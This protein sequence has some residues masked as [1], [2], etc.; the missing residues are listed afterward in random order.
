MANVLRR[1]RY[2]ASWTRNVCV[3]TLRCCR[4]WTMWALAIIIIFLLFI[5][6]KESNNQA[7]E[8]LNSSSVTYRHD[9]SEIISECR[10]EF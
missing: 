10:F 5:R 3:N 4:L 6:H 1:K 2:V 9:V 7:N 8:P